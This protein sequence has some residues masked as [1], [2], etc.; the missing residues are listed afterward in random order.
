[1]GRPRTILA[2][3]KVGV[4]AG[5]G[6]NPRRVVGV[7]F[8]IQRE[9]RQVRGAGKGRQR[10]RAG[11]V[12]E[13][14]RSRQFRQVI[15]A[16]RIVQAFGAGQFWQVIGTGQLRKV[17]GTRQVI[18]GVRPRDLAHRRR[19][20]N[21]VGPRRVVV[22]QLDIAR[23]GDRFRSGH[24]SRLG[25]VRSRHFRHGSRGSRTVELKR[26]E[27]VETDLSRTFGY[28]VRLE[29]RISVTG[30]QLKVNIVAIGGS[31]NTQLAVFDLTLDLQRPVAE[32]AFQG[33]GPD[34]EDRQVEADLLAR[35]RIVV[36]AN[37]QVQA[38]APAA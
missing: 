37:Q 32:E 29:S 36:A 27:A 23:V 15:R 19:V 34:P 14:F 3:E 26:R 31:A 30:K 21:S 33:V 12:V 16:R 13:A 6:G 24:R 22:N 17:I 18:K 2:L 11:Q 5:G 25:N 10:L 20:G 35:G 4:R 28:K 7:A 38:T 1:M 8:E 9:V